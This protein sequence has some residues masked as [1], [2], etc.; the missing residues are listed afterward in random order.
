LAGF[1]G[2]ADSGQGS[3]RTS[4]SLTHQRCWARLNE[5]ARTSNAA[6]LGRS[7]SRPQ[8]LGGLFSLG[9]AY[10]RARTLELRA[11]GGDVTAVDRDCEEIE[12]SVSMLMTELKELRDRL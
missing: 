4:F 9:E 12:R 5:A 6:D 8:G 7:R 3:H 1:A 11:R 10:D 2:R